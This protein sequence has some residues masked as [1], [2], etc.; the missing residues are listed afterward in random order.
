MT[1]WLLTQQG[2]LSLAL[3]LL[4]LANRFVLPRAGADFC[5]KLWAV[6]P[7]GL[8][9]LN[10]PDAMKPNGSTALTRYRVAAEQTVT[11]QQMFDWTALYLVVAAVLAGVVL[12]AHW[13][14][15]RNLAL[16]PARLAETAG[17]P[18]FFSDAV[19][20]PML[21]GFFRP[22]LVLPSDA[23]QT[24]SHEELRLILRHEQ[25]HYQ[26]G[27]NQ[28]NLLALALAITFWFNPLV[29]LA[30]RQFRLQQELSC[31]Q[32]VLSGQPSEQRI[33]YAKALV[34][35]AAASRRPL[36]AYSHYGAKN[37]MMKRLN[38]IKTNPSGHMLGKGLMMVSLCVLLGPLAFAKAPQDKKTETVYPVMRVEPVYPANAIAQK[39][40][41][42]VVLKF[43][44]EPDGA[45]SRIS[46]IRANP[47]HIFDNAAK[48]ALAQWRY[49][50][51]KSGAQN[52]LVQLDF[53]MDA[54][55]QPRD[56]IERIKISH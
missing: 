35:C 52:Q 39:Q 18:A 19:A 8:L 12:L 29:W 44:I 5:Y 41:G 25:I 20:S 42:S 50:T 37:T 33:H 28:A 7:F 38:F 46:V 54:S 6:V 17:L 23:M 13:R 27:D 22:C 30:Y 47:Q 55:A 4:I 24:Y 11:T 43:D 9:L 2:T 26:R 49:E 31:D 34:R 3:L 45:T 56:E 21:V 51:S 14:F 16:R 48:E 10:M 32:R 53:V 1:D 36:Y 40:S 15:Y